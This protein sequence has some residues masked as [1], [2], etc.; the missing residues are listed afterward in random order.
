[1]ERIF[2][3]GQTQRRKAGKPEADGADV[4]LRR[5]HL[6][7]AAAVA[8]Q[9]FGEERQAYVVYYPARHS[10]LLAPMSDTAFKQLHDAALVMLKVRNAAGDRSLSL[11]EVVIDNDLDDTDRPLE[12]VQRP[13]LR[14]LNV[15]I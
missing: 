12:F 6:W 13:G 2:H 7:I 8:N 10:L 15:S 11:Q 3:L 4:Q 5:K 1:M 9:V 14:L